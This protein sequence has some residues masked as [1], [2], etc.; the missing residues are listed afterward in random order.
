MKPLIL[1]CFFFLWISN[2]RE[3][4]HLSQLF[5]WLLLLRLFFQCRSNNFHFFLLLSVFCF[6]FGCGIRF[7]FLWTFEPG[8]ATSWRMNF[9]DLVSV[10]IQNPELIFIVGLQ[11]Q[12]ENS[13]LEIFSRMFV[14][15]YFGTVRPYFPM[16]T[17]IAFAVDS[18][19]LFWRRSFA[20]HSIWISS[21]SSQVFL[22]RLQ[23]RFPS[24]ELKIHSRFCRARFRFGFITFW[25][26][27]RFS[28]LLVV[29]LL[30][31]EYL[32]SFLELFLL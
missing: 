3:K 15:V 24:V 10:T 21:L 13:S 23:G 17:T 11:P 29:R 18:S 1:K 5:S 14:V 25:S 22:P 26:R 16:L 12:R 31:V 6:D 9:P 4:L 30:S 19:Q 7:S 32:F 8:F 27:R 2:H 28:L 20:Y